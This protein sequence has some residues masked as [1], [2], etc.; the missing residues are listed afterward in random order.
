MRPKQVRLYRCF[1]CG[2]E[3]L[4]PNSACGDCKSTDPNYC[5][6]PPG[7]A[8]KKRAHTKITPD[9]LVRIRELLAKGISGAAIARQYGVIPQTISAIKT[10]RARKQKETTV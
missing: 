1:R 6:T 8:R 3:V 7:T 9:D 5:K 4:E 2:I 10:G